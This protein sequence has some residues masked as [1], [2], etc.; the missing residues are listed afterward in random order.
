MVVVLGGEGLVWGEEKYTD[1][2]RR[3]KIC[4]THIKYGQTQ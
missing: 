2:R 4:E 1:T 3:V